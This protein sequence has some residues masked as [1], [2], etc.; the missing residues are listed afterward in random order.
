MCGG[1]GGEEDNE[2]SGLKITLPYV[3]WEETSTSLFETSLLLGVESVVCE[4]MICLQM[5]VCFCV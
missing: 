1:V 4:C 3:M 2:R 5:A